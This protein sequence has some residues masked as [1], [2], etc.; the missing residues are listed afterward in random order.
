MIKTKKGVVKANGK[1][2]ELL[3]DLCCIVESLH[4]NFSREIDEELSKKL[5]FDAIEIVFMTEDEREKRAKSNI[6]KLCEEINKC[7]EDET[8]E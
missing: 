4:E 8:D 1:G 7:L 5:I 6:R 3:S 2:S